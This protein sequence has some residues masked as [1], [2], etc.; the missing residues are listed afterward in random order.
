MEVGVRA[1]KAH[2]SE[3]LDRAE[4]GESILVTDRGRAKAMLVAVPG[5][6]RLEAGIADGWITRGTGGPLRPVH[7]VRAE[8]WTGAVL[9]ED[10]GA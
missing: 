8:Q 2:L 4:R 7:R 9:D 10:R 3:Y 5:S 6:D 1:L